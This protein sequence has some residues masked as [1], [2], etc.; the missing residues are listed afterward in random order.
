MTAAAP[1][2]PRVAVPGLYAQLLDDAAVFPPGNA[3]M[4]DALRAHARTRTSA[5]AAYVGSFVCTAGRL[6]ELVAA[7]PPDLPALTLSLVVPPGVEALGPALTAVARQHRLVLRAV[8]LPAGTAGAAAT[9][10]ALSALL[11]PGAT[12]YV[13]LPFD[14]ELPTSVTVLA[15]TPHRLKL[16]T[17]G[18]SAAAF[19]TERALAAA[20]AACVG[21]GL[22][23]KLTAGLHHAVRSTDPST[24]FE[25]HGFLGVLVAV[26]RALGGAPLPD[27]VDALAERDPAVVAARVAGMEKPRAREVRRWFTSFGTCTT[28]EPLA[29]LRAL[30]LVP[31]EPATPAS[32][33]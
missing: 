7:L 3:P 30:G 5:D 11:P 23:F 20:V 27:L 16:R 29:D 10:E 28:S 32:S 2:A 6:D 31:T 33:A 8:E 4:A 25:H 21:A 1:T 12:G 22:P 24:G 18:E 14:D 15:G 19:P 17:G 26:S 9:A 13:E